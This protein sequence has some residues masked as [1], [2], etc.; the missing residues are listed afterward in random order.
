VLRSKSGHTELS[1]GEVLVGRSRSCQV[2]LRDPSVSRSHALITVQGESLTLKDLASSN[3]TFVNG[4]KVEGEADLAAGDHL[5]FGETQLELGLLDKEDAFSFAGLIEE[6]EFETAEARAFNPILETLKP[7]GVSQQDLP[8]ED[9]PSEDQS[10]HELSSQDLSLDLA[11]SEDHGGSEEE[12]AF[13]GEGGVDLRGDY[14]PSLEIDGTPMGGVPLTFEEPT[15]EPLED[16]PLE[17]APLEDG[18]SLDEA[19]R[20]KPPEGE[21]LRAGALPELPLDEA[22]EELDSLL[23]EKLDPPKKPEAAVKPPERQPA[24][25]VSPPPLS[26]RSKPTPDIAP[27]LGSG[28]VKQ[29]VDRLLHEDDAAA[30]P[31]APIPSRDSSFLDDTGELL[32]SLGDLDNLDALGAPPLAS[33]GPSSSRVSPPISSPPPQSAGAR[34]VASLD[35]APTPRANPNSLPAAGFGIRLVATL[36]DGMLV[37]VVAGVISLLVG[38]GPWIAEGGAVFFSVILGLSFV[39]HVF[40]WNLWGTTP[41]KRLFG[42]YVCPVG[43]AP[44]I[45]VGSAVLRFVG[46]V[47]GVLSLGLGFLMVAF[48]PGRR[49]LHDIVAGTYV[50]RWQR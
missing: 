29:V 22:L 44:G 3:G 31:A 24:K 4:D 12:P 9:L 23:S 34:S 48:T 35:R 13:E 15:L 28:E 49:G 16:E 27:A 6:V 21:P 20:Y 42:L 25:V 17:E 47:V 26:R 36:L 41:A 30:K 45:S 5:T 38:G 46:Y 10:S 33:Q 32:P 50:G 43:G 18:P 11:V 14:G 40:G 7:G 8:S 1:Q 37:M 2:V 19:Q 39:L